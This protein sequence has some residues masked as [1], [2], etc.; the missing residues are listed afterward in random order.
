MDLA[1]TLITVCVILS[2]YNL[3]EAQRLLND[4]KAY[5]EKAERLLA[6]VKK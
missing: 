6:E 3:W 1:W 4:A 5:Y 2:W